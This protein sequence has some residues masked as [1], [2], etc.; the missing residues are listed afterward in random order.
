MLCTAQLRSSIFSP[1]G[2][3]SALNPCVFVTGCNL[4]WKPQVLT[5]NAPYRNFWNAV[6]SLFNCCFLLFTAVFSPFLHAVFSLFP[7]KAL[8][9]LWF[10]STQIPLKS[11][12]A[13]LLLIAPSNSACSRGETSPGEEL[14]HVKTSCT[15]PSSG[16][17]WH[18]LLIDL[19]AAFPAANSSFLCRFCVEGK[20]GDASWTSPRLGDAPWSELSE[21]SSAF[22]A[23]LP[24]F[25]SCTNST[26]IPTT[27]ELKE[28]KISF[29]ERTATIYTLRMKTSSTQKIFRQ[30]FQN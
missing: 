20:V 10:F 25:V 9:A 11:P 16:M 22:L 24:I 13:P 21:Q 12:G 27:Q 7:H 29:W 30:V 6:S 17:K 18:K 15:A 1:D 2:G 3:K 5:P 26:N 28:K 19:Q 23:F 8:W 4:S 14:P